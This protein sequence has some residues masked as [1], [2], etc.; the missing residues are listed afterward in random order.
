M[1]RKRSYR[2]RRGNAHVT[3][4]RLSSGVP[5]RRERSTKRQ[6]A[7]VK[8]L[9]HVFIPVEA[10]LNDKGHCQQRQAG[11]SAEQH[12]DV[13]STERNTLMLLLLARQLTQAE[14][15]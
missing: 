10:H 8:S 4:E 12:V 1:Y 3:S 9:D 5:T 11:R 13:L 6:Q 2:Y 7:E 15:C 14:I